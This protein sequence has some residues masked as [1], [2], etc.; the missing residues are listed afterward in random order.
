[1][2]TEEMNDQ[3]R[4]YLNKVL[5]YRKHMEKEHLEN[6]LD[7]WKEICPNLKDEEKTQLYLYDLERF[8]KK[9]KVKI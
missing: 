4:D 2:M 3:F 5:Y 1:M 6:V 7:K 9:F 8:L